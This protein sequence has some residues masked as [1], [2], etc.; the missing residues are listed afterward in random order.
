MHSFA[1]YL[2]TPLAHPPSGLTPPLACPPPPLAQPNP[3]SGSTPPLARPQPSPTQP[4]STPTQL[5]PSSNPAPTQP[6]PW[7]RPDPTPIQTRSDPDPDLSLAPIGSIHLFVQKHT[8]NT[9]TPLRWPLVSA[10]LL[11]FSHMSLEPKTC[12]FP[13]FDPS[14]NPHFLPFSVLWLISTNELNSTHLQWVEVSR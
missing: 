12:D 5:Q 6:Q 9:G 3:P 8:P 14:P 1:L 10:R 13:E 2:V 7:P 4:N 11:V